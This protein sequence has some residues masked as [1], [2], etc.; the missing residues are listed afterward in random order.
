[1]MPTIVKRGCQGRCARGTFCIAAYCSAASSGCH[2]FAL[3][4]PGEQFAN[5]LPQFAALVLPAGLLLLRGFFLAVEKLLA[6]DQPR[7][8]AFDVVPLG[9]EPRL[10]LVALLDEPL[11]LQI[12]P[13]HQPHEL[14][15]LR[16]ALFVRF[17][18]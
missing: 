14:R 17:A 3:S 15:L 10:Q 11:L 9:F 1:M 18:I 4:Q 7:R 2:G 5:A 12:E 13:L 6:A 8:L 16:R